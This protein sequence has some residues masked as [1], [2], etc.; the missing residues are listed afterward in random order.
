MT[1]VLPAWKLELIEKKKKK[2]QDQRQKFE[3][4]KSRKV[5][6]P[7]W[8]RSLL[9]KKKECSSDSPGAAEQAGGLSVNSV[10]G[11]RIVRRTSE[12]TIAIANASQRPVSKVESEERRR[13]QENTTHHRNSASDAADSNSCVTRAVEIPTQVGYKSNKWGSLQR[14][15]VNDSENFQRS[16]VT[17]S[18]EDL[19]VPAASDVLVQSKTKVFDDD[20]AKGSSVLAYK[21]MFEQ[22]QPGDKK[23]IN[24][25][26]TESIK[27]D[28][29]SDKRTAESKLDIANDNSQ[30]Q[31]CN[32]RTLLGD[33]GQSIQLKKSANLHVSETNETKISGPSPSTTPKPYKNFVSTP[34]WLKNSN[35][36]KNITFL[37]G[38]KSVQEPVVA[39][40]HTE[41]E[42]EDNDFHKSDQNSITVESDVTEKA[43]KT[44]NSIDSVLPTSAIEPEKQKPPENEVEERAQQLLQDQTDK[45]YSIVKQSDADKEQLPVIKSGEGSETQKYVLI[46]SRGQQE[47]TPSNE[48]TIAVVSRES[49]RHVPNEMDNQEGTENNVSGHSSID[50]LRSKF[51][52]SVGF[53]RRSSSEENLFLKSSLS[54]PIKQESVLRR[55]GQ[56]K[57]TQPAM[58]RWSADVLSLMSQPIDG[59]DDDDGNDTSKLSPR[60][61]SKIPSANSGQAKRPPPPKKRWTADVLSK[62][63]QPVDDDTSNLSPRSDSSKKSSP[64]HSLN[65]ARSSSWSDLWEELGFDYFHH[66]ANVSQGIEHRMHKL[67][68]K[69][70]ISDIN[71]NAEEGDSD[72]LSDEDS[73]GLNDA[74]LHANEAPN[75]PDTLK[76]EITDL[77]PTDTSI[78]EKDSKQPL[79]SAD[80]EAQA[81][82][83]RKHS[84]SHDIEHR[85]CELF[86]RQVSQQSDGGESDGERT[87]ENDAKIT[88]DKEAEKVPD[89]MF[90]K[91]KLEPTHV[92]GIEKSPPGYVS[93]TSDEESAKEDLDQI[94]PESKPPKGSV[95]KL[96]ALFGSSIWKPNKKNKGSSDENPK[97][98]ASAGSKSQK[99]S[100]TEKST[101]T[102][103][104]DGKKTSLFSKSRKTEGK[105]EQK[106]EKEQSNGNIIPWLKKHDKAK[107]KAGESK[108]TDVKDKNK[109][110]S[111]SGSTEQDVDNLFIAAH[112]LQPVRKAE[113]VEQR[114]VGKVMIISNASHEQVPPKGVYHKPK[115]S[116]HPP[117]PEEKTFAKKE[118]TSKPV[119]IER[120]EKTFAKKEETS[121][122]VENERSKAQIPV[123]VTQHWNGNEKSPVPEQNRKGSIPITTIDEVPISAID[124]PESGEGDVSVSVIDVPSSP[125]VRSAGKFA[126]LNGN[127]EGETHTDDDDVSVS[128]ID[129]PSPVA[130]EDEP[131]TFQGG[132]L[133]T[134]ELSD[135]SD[136]DEVEGSY[137]F[138]TGEITHVVNGD[139]AQDDD[140]DDEEEEEDD[141]SDDEDVPISYIGESPRY[142]VPQV[143]FESE[144]VQLKSCLSPKTERRKVRSENRILSHVHC[145]LK[146][147]L[148]HL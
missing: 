123:V 135:E 58:V 57:R 13:S 146:G 24:E 26:N 109:K 30:S 148:W 62:I 108:T 101:A 49:V 104:E 67:I 31:I 141:D 42:K 100:S 134:D 19:K 79:V 46:D 120:S 136:S 7:E 131:N 114:L 71:L 1:S 95:H 48:N 16:D 12:K 144:P 38:N 93:T 88:T 11:P 17:S 75:A 147:P 56:N 125:D 124:I 2:E 5:S 32:K 83:A 36:P 37:A 55:P 22:P 94:A 20:H 80:Q 133:E 54:E 143:V 116:F 103:K 96:S 122:P 51:G 128:V 10:F 142:K 87:L 44:S 119:E 39:N 21:R 25:P 81:V 145:R 77:T 99:I 63:S 27:T 111:S 138:A 18:R 73:A 4:E 61:E 89:A 23:E 28:F 40:V 15:I 50:S 47:P 92:V 9:E 91:V 78:K 102:K 139:I 106:K 115:A 132:Y 127:T 64:S 90:E 117:E 98:K 110:N 14:G 130:K 45:K 85:V 43:E 137:D 60:S 105:T 35:S 113:K 69:A 72:S 53:R 121:K 86:H 97:E 107:N 68:R 3:D 76:N 6:I 74:D 41:I 112:N 66:K 8:K 140:D 59:D 129:L 118:N 65:R 126:F 34:P 70:S 82:F 29:R 84:I 52:P 33:N